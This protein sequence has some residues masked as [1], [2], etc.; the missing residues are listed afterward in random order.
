MWGLCVSRG[1]GA[2]RVQEFEEGRGTPG[3]YTVVREGGLPSS[4]TSNLCKMHRL[5]YA[6]QPY[7]NL[8]NAS[9]TA[10]RN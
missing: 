9:S 2:G 10:H 4:S 5:L 6:Q 1:T 3:R 7:V 8:F